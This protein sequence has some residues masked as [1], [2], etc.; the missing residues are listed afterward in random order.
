LEEWL[1]Y[2]HKLGFDK[3]IMYQNDW[4]CKIDKP[5]LEKHIWDGGSV[6]LPIYDNA[7]VNHTE[8][9][10]VALIDCDEFIVLNKHNN[11]KDFIEEYKDRTD[12]IGLNWVMHG[13]LGMVNRTC[14]SLLTMFPMRGTNPDQHIK[15]IVKTGTGHRMQLPHNC[16]N[17]SM[18]TNGKVFRGPFNPGGPIDIA[19]ISHFHNKTREDW[20]LR[21]DRGR[22]DCDVPHDRDRW[23]NEIN[24]NNEVE[25]K[26]AYNFLYGTN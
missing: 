3:I 22:V 9:D 17:A 2:N 19:Y 21:C 6:Q 15:V 11:I 20:M 23:D 16:N 26:S 13:N 5:Y 1:E 14:N 24:I 4:E 25:D 12:I 7:I 10:F 8:Y 18:D